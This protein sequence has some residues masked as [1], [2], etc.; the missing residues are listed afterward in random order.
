MR[1]K[2]SS[3]T[4]NLKP[5]GAYSPERLARRSKKLSL[6]QV[7]LLRPNRVGALDRHRPPRSEAGSARAASWAPTAS[8]QAAWTAS[9]V[10]GAPCSRAARMRGA[11]RAEEH[12]GRH[13]ASAPDLR[14]FAP[15]HPQ[16]AAHRARR[17]RLLV[18]GGDQ[19]LAATLE[20]R[21]QPLAPPRV[22]LAHHV[23][24]QQQ[25]RHPA[26]LEQRVALGEEQGAG[27]AR[28]CPC[29]P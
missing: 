1:L 8:A 23:V 5:S 19:R 28:C 22:E 21:D 18:G 24:E 6:H 14:R 3:F 7:E 13:A 2:R 4:R 9:P 29:E 11:G 20:P 27:A 16:D 10:F 15:G 26:R 12:G 25:R 17:E